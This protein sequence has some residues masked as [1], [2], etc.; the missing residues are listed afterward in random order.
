MNLF[1]NKT[2]E[3]NGKKK[4]A[5]ALDKIHFLEKITEI[6]SEQWQLDREIKSE[7]KISKVQK[8]T[9]YLLKN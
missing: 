2:T 8:I 4:E 1:T 7:K 3:Q 9:K 5:K 6:E